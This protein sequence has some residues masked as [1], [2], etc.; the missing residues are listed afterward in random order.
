MTLKIWI[1]SFIPKDIAGYTMAVPGQA[2]RSMI[3]G[4]TPLSDCFHTDQRGFS[5]D[6]NASAR[7]RSLVE[8][9]VAGA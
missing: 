7:M 4:P 3:P 5:S 2:G 6:P 9:R 1:S 8:L